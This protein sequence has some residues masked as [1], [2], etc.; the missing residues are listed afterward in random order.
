MNKRKSLIIIALLLTSVSLSGCNEDSNKKNDIN[1]F[2][3]TWEGTSFFQNETTDVSLTFYEDNTL[4]QISEEIHTH[5]F[6]Y[7]LENNC[8]YMEFPE[9]PEGYGICYNYEFSNNNTALTLTNESLDTLVLNK[10]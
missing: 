7:K 9:L 1:K 10:I 8:L 4:K 2:I 6:N 5:W 3:G